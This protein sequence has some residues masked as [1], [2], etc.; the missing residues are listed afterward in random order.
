MRQFDYTK[1]ANRTWDNDTVNLLTQIHEA[2]G[3]LEAQLAHNPNEQ[4]KAVEIVKLKSAEASNEI[5]GI[6][7]SSARLKQLISGR[8]DPRTRSEQEIAG[9]RD[10]LSEVLETPE[11]IPV[12]TD[13]ILRLHDILF[14]HRDDASRGRL[15][16]TQNYISSRD[17]QGKVFTLFTPLAPYEAGPALERICAEY[18]RV[19]EAGRVDPLIVIP[20]FIHD[21][22]CIH[23]FDEG[24]GRMSRLL[25][26]LLLYRSGYSIV[27]FIS[28][29]AKIA[30]DK[31]GY[32]HALATSQYAW[33]EGEDDPRPFIKYLLGT[34]ASAYRDFEEPAAAMSEDAAPIDM[35]RRAAAAEDDRF[36]KADI[37]R[38]TPSLS[39]ATVERAIKKLCDDG[40]LEKRGQGRSTYYLKRDAKTQ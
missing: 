5:E 19:I 39:V 34:I 2:K 38:K 16:N 29:E 7:V 31:D 12:T 26:T 24:N 4:V 28:P 11:C 15:K 14:S 40:E 32:Y 36:T 1:L 9:Y 33:H 10:A 8:S 3:R 22:L 37:M 35:V 6:E 17:E 25:T 27:K 13:G 18:N 23:P 21:F 30:E 20:V